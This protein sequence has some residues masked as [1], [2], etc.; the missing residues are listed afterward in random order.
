MKDEVH[1]LEVARYVATMAADKLA[2]WDELTESQLRIC[3][4]W[5]GV[6]MDSIDKAIKERKGEEV[7]K[8]TRAKLVKIHKTGYL[9]T[10]AHIRRKG[11]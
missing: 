2:Y 1:K 9:A 4:T 6:A 10:G 7:E 11:K 8:P 5:L 3:S